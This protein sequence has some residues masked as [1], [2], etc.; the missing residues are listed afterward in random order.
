MWLRC[1]QSFGESEA[2]YIIQRGVGVQVKIGCCVK[3]GSAIECGRLTSVEYSSRHGNK[4]QFAKGI[5][6]V[7][8]RADKKD[9]DPLMRNWGQTDCLLYQP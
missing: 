3:M 9:R 7:L 6:E 8:V 1:L 5:K 2:W 4:Q